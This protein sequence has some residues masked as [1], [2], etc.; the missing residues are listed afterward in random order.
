M[1]VRAHVCVCVTER[2]DKRWRVGGR[3]G[4]KLTD[5][6]VALEVILFCLSLSLSRMFWS[7]AA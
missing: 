2:E 6:F 4:G 1:C 3:M 7:H 5:V